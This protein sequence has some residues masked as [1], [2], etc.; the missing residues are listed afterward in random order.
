MRK[1]SYILSI[2]R[3]LIKFC[4]HDPETLFNLPS[5]LI[6]GNDFC[7]FSIGC[8]SAHLFKTHR[9]LQILYL[10]NYTRLIN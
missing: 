10:F 4:L 5:T 9:Q 3:L 1:C 7:R 2:D 6:D 8:D